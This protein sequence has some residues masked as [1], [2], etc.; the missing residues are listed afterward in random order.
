M[1]FIYLFYL[2]SET[3]NCTEK[4]CNYTKKECNC[5]ETNHPIWV[6]FLL[7]FLFSVWGTYPCYL[8]RFGAKT[9]NLLSSGAKISHARCAHC[10]YGFHWFCHGV[11]VFLMLL[12][13]LLHGLHSFFHSVH[14]IFDL[15]CWF[16]DAVGWF[17]HGLSD[18]S[19]DF[20]DV[21]MVFIKF[22]KCSLILAWFS[23][24]YLGI[25]DVHKS[26]CK[27]LDV[28]PNIYI[29]IYIYTHIYI[30]YH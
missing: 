4:D 26:N 20:I 7:F 18:F 3:S 11:H 1:C 22:C 2:L 17:L 5:I 28:N 16:L 13:E 30:L 9:C 12:A 21:A 23:K 14:G 29:I 8:L 24:V 27:Y 10:F 25:H 19:M 15:F 6:Q